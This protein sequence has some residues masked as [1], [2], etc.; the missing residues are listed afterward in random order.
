VFFGRLRFANTAII[1]GIENPCTAGT[2]MKVFRPLLIAGL[3]LTHLAAHA[4]SFDCNRGHSLTEKMICNDP[5]L[6]KLDDTLGQLYWKAR[7]RVTNRRAF[8]TDSDSKW[9]WREENCRDAACLDK[10]YTTRIDELQRLIESMQTGTGQAVV[11]A[12][13]ALPA[14]APA[15]AAKDPAASAPMPETPAPR[16]PAKRSLAAARPLEATLLQCT[17]ANP[18][19]VVNDQC[20]TVLKQSGNQWK[21]QPRGGDWFCGVATLAQ[22]SAN[23]QVDAAQ[24]DGDQ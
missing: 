9:T 12:S 24:S 2:A 10:W 11:A 13:S 19:L 23:A 8:L 6:S 7:R 18:G 14:V 4:T 1:D 21:Y 3:M 20:S 17:A 16:S 15:A 5:A 22:P